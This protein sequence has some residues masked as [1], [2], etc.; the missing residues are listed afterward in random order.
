[1][2]RD[3]TL[4]T[5]LEKY[6]VFDAISAESLNPKILETRDRALN[7]KDLST[8]YLLDEPFFTESDDLVT[9][10]APFNENMGAI[11]G[12]TLDGYDTT[13]LQ[14]NLVTS[15]DLEWHA[16]LIKGV[17]FTSRPLQKKILAGLPEELNIKSMTLHE[18]EEYELSARQIPTFKFIRLTIGPTVSAAKP[19]DRAAIYVND[20]QYGLL[21]PKLLAKIVVIQLHSFL[22]EELKLR[23][24]W[25]PI[26]LAFAQYSSSEGWQSL[27]EYRQIQAAQKKLVQ[28]HFPL[29]KGP[30]TFLLRVSPPAPKA[31]DFTETYDKNLWLL[32][33]ILLKGLTGD[34]VDEIWKHKH[35]KARSFLKYLQIVQPGVRFQ[36]AHTNT[37]PAEL[38]IEL[39]K[40]TAAETE[41]LEYTRFKMSP[42]FNLAEVEPKMMMDAFGQIQF[43][44]H[45]LSP[46]FTAGMNK[47]LASFL[48]F[49]ASAIWLIMKEAEKDLSPQER[50]PGLTLD[51]K[52]PLISVSHIQFLPFA[53]P[54]DLGFEHDI[55]AETDDV[56]DN[57]LPTYIPANPTFIV[58]PP[59][60][61]LPPEQKATVRIGHTSVYS[62]LRTNFFLSQEVKEDRSPEALEAVEE[63]AAEFETLFPNKEKYFLILCMSP[64]DIEMP[65]VKVQWLD[66]DENVLRKLNILLYLEIEAFT[67]GPISREQFGELLPFYEDG[68]DLDLLREGSDVA[69]ELQT[70]IRGRMI[71]Q[72]AHRHPPRNRNSSQLPDTPR[73]VSMTLRLRHYYYHPHVLLVVE[74]SKPHHKLALSHYNL[75]KKVAI[76]FRGKVID[77]IRNDVTKPEETRRKLCVVDDIHLLF[78]TDDD[79]PDTYALYIAKD[80]A[81]KLEFP[82][83]E[84]EKTKK[85]K[86]KKG[87]EKKEGA[88]GA[89]DV[90]E[91]R[92][93]EVAKPKGQAEEAKKVKEKAK[94][95]VM[96]KEEEVALLE[97]GAATK[98][99][100]K[101]RKSEAVKEEVKEEEMAEVLKVEDLGVG[102]K[103]KKKKKKKKVLCVD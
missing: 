48:R 18:I 65:R 27:R 97:E 29:F 10:R 2:G 30:T 53:S 81:E 31:K 64:G 16:I 87:K 44:F 74:L 68:L 24:Y 38:K 55:V 52:P 50:T 95:K 71:R 85:R 41:K 83:E 33:G 98:K 21:Y 1:M 45:C 3:E 39:V 20:N 73:A 8:V 9:R 102:Q 69:T 72:N 88:I 37:T 92:D 101:K 12:M 13:R 11:I 22:T 62:L 63:K 70:R 35:S 90:G 76:D 5:F 86:R 91:R 51:G 49:W 61:P 34:I 4:V 28:T 79:A 47:V 26:S 17:D 25:F 78:A 32:H 58:T 82:K 54:V 23:D 60:P 77:M 6:D 100:K 96:E 99:K 67:D 89:E 19:D 59:V 94:G 14:D 84:K 57:W 93:T 7:I 15:T 40:L 42:N 103:K 56:Y 66:L 36:T 43:K 46:P 75:A 80:P